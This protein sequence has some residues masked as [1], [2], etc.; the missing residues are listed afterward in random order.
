MDSGEWRPGRALCGKK[1]RLN[2]S[3]LD[4]VHLQSVGAKNVRGT[5]KW[6]FKTHLVSRKEDLENQHQVDSKLPA[7]AEH[8]SVAKLLHL[9]PILA[10]ALCRALK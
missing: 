9:G 1:R 5:R 6:H 7:F 4:T 2:S 3:I 8:I 10:P